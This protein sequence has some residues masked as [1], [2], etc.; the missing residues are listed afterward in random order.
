MTTTIQADLPQ[1]RLRLDRDVIAAIDADIK[2][3]TFRSRQEAVAAALSAYFVTGKRSD[4]AIIKQTDKSLSFGL[5]AFLL[6][7]RDGF[8]QADADVLWTA[9]ENLAGHGYD[10]PFQYLESVGL[11]RSKREAAEW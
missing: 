4:S 1:L 6:L 3:G 7:H 9:A 8:S 11:P 5:F 10:L 2:A